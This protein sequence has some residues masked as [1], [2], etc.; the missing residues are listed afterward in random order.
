MTKNEFKKFFF[1]FCKERGIYCFITREIKKEHRN[2]DTFYT[3]AVTEGKSQV[4]N[5]TS[6]LTFSWRENFDFWRNIHNEW[7]STLN[8]AKNLFAKV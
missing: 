7:V 2:F 6:I 4:F 8:K 1:R 5:K 3:V